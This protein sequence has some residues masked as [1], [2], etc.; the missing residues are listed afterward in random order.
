MLDIKIGVW[1]V[2]PNHVV[3]RFGKEL[4]IRDEVLTN[5]TTNEREET[6]LE[7]NNAYFNKISE[8]FGPDFEV[9]HKND[10]GVSKKSFYEALLRDTKNPVVLYLHGQT[11]TRGAQHRV[12]MYQVLRAQGFHVITFDYRSYG[13]SSNLG[14]SARAVILDSK[15]VYKYIVETTDN[16]ILIWG[17][18]LGTGIGTHLIT[19]L[20][21][22]DIRM[23]Q[24]IILESPF[25]NIKDEIREH[26]F[27]RAFKYLPWFE[28]TVVSPMFQNQLTF[29]S[30]DLIADIELPI[31]I[32]HAEDDHVVPFRLGYKLY[33][34]GLKTRPKN[35]APIEFYRFST[36]HNYGHRWICRAP[37]LPSLINGFFD[38]YEGDGSYSRNK[39]KK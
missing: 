29:N 3:K 11:A 27:A 33:R 25:N 21:Q 9:Q 17:H 36:A 22:M 6:L 20:Q 38:K 7:V 37:E 19:E 15:N 34:A 32:L 26:P 13:D 16:P 14:P 5:I 31:M 2:L 4:K 8:R 18:S 12:D 1:H 28:F 24:G 39:T 23:P 35:F 10:N 30:D